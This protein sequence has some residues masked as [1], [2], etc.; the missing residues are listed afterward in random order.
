MQVLVHPRGIRTERRPEESRNSSAN[1]LDGRAP[2][3]LHVVAMKTTTNTNA[4]ATTPAQARAYAAN[5]LALAAPDAYE[6]AHEAA[7]A[8]RAAYAANP[9][10]AAAYWA[11]IE[12]T[13][14]AARL[15]EK[16]ERLAT[17]AAWMCRMAR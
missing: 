4:R 10:D 14:I 15:E 13:A 3:W 1:C 7:A 6:A 17:R 2:G 5:R 11:A 12:A 16:A 8:A 9:T